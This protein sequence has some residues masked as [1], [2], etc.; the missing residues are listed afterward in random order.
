LTSNTDVARAVWSERYGGLT[1]SLQALAEGLDA[2]GARPLFRMAPS[3]IPIAPTRSGRLRCRHPGL[4]RADLGPAEDQAGALVHAAASAVLD[5]LE[6]AIVILRFDG[7][8]LVANP[9]ARH[10]EA[11][12]DCF[13]ISGNSIRLLDQRCQR[14]LDSLIAQRLSGHTRQIELLRLPSRTASAHRYQLCVEWLDLL[15]PFKDPVLAL[16]I[17]DS[18]LAGQ[19]NHELLARLFRL[20]RMECRLVDALFTDPIL[21]AAAARCG[22][23]L[24]TAKTHLKH[25]FAKCGV[26][27]KA[28]LFRLLALGPRAL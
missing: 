8:V 12:G 10:I 27:S 7:H 6:R 15:R 2:D 28:E 22:I 18:Q 26:C 17:H 4:R 14:V 24:N 3:L 11:R 5:R 13:R 21:Q 25:V 19:L 16:S 20:T 9:A 23:A 1:E